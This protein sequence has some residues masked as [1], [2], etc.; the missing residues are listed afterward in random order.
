MAH[1]PLQPGKVRSRAAQALAGLISQE[2]STLVFE[3][4]RLIILELAK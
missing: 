3:T 1:F 4:T 2:P